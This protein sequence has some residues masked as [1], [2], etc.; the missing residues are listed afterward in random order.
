MPIIAVSITKD[1]DQ[2]ESEGI[3]LET[4]KYFQTG[5]GFLKPSNQNRNNSLINLSFKWPSNVTQIT[6]MYDHIVLSRLVSS[7]VKIMNGCT[8]AFI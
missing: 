4:N 6:V 1:L 3:F 2:N 7:F 5:V 8:K